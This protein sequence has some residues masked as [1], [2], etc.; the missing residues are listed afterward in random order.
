MKKKFFMAYPYKPKGYSNFRTVNQRDA[1]IKKMHQ[2]KME[3]W[4]NKDF[5]YEYG[6]SLGQAINL[7][8]E[9]GIPIASEKFDEQVL[10][11]FKKNLALKNDARFREAFQAFFDDRAN[12]NA[13]SM[14]KEEQRLED[15]A[16]G[17][18]D[19]GPDEPSV[20]LLS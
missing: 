19:F 20:N 6:V 2:N 17:P 11:I 10:N 18:E 14:E 7:A 15:A 5:N 4:A 8:L 16:G 12:L 3:Y 1:D 13:R 9:S